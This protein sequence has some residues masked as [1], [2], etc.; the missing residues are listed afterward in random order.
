MEVLDPKYDLMSNEKKMKIPTEIAL[1][2]LQFLKIEPLVYV[3]R[4]KSLKESFSFNSI[5]AHLI[6]EPNYALKSEKSESSKLDLD[7][8]RINASHNDS[9][10]S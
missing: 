8:S 9:I 1:V 3:E 6:D 5:K 4:I 7:K 2:L 10:S